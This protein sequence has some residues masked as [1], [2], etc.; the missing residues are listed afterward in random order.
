MTAY[1]SSRQIVLSF[2]AARQDAKA[3]A[4]ELMDESFTFESP[5]MRINDRDG[6]LRTHRGFQPLVK[7][8][9]MLSELY[10]SDEA[11]L[12]YDLDIATPPCVERTAEHIRIAGGKVASI[13]LLFDTAPWR[14]IFL[15]QD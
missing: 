12:L 5:L 13:L 2:L 11:I 6:Y 9:R 1:V 8:T 10:G 14:A 4:A 7:S 3:D 15:S